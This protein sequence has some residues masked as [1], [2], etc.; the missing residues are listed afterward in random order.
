MLASQRRKTS[1]ESYVCFFQYVQSV[2]PV[3]RHVSEPLRP[4][5]C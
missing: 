5:P 3:H 4:I 2:W 1:K